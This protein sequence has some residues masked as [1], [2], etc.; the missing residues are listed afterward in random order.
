MTS[1][2]IKKNVVNKY[3]TDSYLRR[4]IYHAYIEDT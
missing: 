2:D 4:D 3:M 1:L